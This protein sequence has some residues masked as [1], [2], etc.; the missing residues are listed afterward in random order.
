M[1]KTRKGGRSESMSAHRA[2]VF[3]TDEDDVIHVEMHSKNGYAAKEADGMLYDAAATS[4]PCACDAVVWQTG[5]RRSP[6]TT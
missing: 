1:K 4:K 6:R 5:D 3:G 2:D